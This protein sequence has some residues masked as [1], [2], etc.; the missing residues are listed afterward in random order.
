MKKVYI[1]LVTGGTNS[2]EG[3]SVSISLIPAFSKPKKKQKCFLR[4]I[5]ILTIQSKS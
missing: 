4:N 1:V 2:G 3:D 5:A